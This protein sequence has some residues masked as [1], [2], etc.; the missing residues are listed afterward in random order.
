MFIKSELKFKIL[1]RSLAL[2]AI[3]YLFVEIKF[4]GR[5]VLVGLVYDPPRVEGLP[6]YLLILEDLVYRYAH[7]IFLGDLNTDLPVNIVR[8]ADLKLR[9]PRT[10]LLIL[11]HCWIFVRPVNLKRSICFLSCLCP[12]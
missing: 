6:I 12:S 7:N 9:L 5:V 3:D 8:A 10:L 4:H 11:Q 1:T 2:L